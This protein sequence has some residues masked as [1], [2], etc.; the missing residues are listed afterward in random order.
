MGAYCP[1]VNYCN[2]NQLTERI[3]SKVALCDILSGNTYTAA[4]SC[5][6][7][8]IF[9]STVKNMAKRILKNPNAKIFYENSYVTKN[10][11]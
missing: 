5:I 8:F 1:A 3:T 9:F 7:I 11:M 6:N 2:G 10:P 4:A